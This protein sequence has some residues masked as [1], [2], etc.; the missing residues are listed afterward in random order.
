VLTGVLLVI[1]VVTSLIALL[2]LS[3]TRALAESAEFWREECYFWMRQFG[4]DEDE[5]D[6]AREN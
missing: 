1:A 5:A 6:E 3:F 2:A 4:D